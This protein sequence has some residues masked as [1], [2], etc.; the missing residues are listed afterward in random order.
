MKDGKADP[1]RRTRTN[2][3]CL[4]KLKSAGIFWDGKRFSGA[5][6]LVAVPMGSSIVENLEKK[7]LNVREVPLHAG[8]PDLM[9][10][11]RVPGFI[12]PETIFDVYIKR[13]PEKYRDIVKVAPP[14]W[15]KPEYFMLSHKFVKEN[16]D[17]ARRIW[18]SI[19]SIRQSAKYRALL[20]QYLD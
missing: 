19:H 13:N 10:Q 12:C 2:A 14:V 5:S 20:R 7:G 9:R 11:K 16:P 17:L 1:T 4:Y 3:Y 18:D 8:S 6:N 15:E